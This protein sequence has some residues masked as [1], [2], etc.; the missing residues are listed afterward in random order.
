MSLAIA[1]VL[2]S[3]LAHATWNLLAARGPGDSRAFLL[4]Y[5]LVGAVAVLP[6]AGVSLA[7][8]SDPGAVLRQALVLGVVSGLLHT[9]YAVSLQVSY[10][11]GD[12]GIVYPV[13]RG[14]GPLLAVLAGAWVASEAPSPLGWA[15]IACVL[16]GVLLA[17]SDQPG[18][19]GSRRRGVRAG[20]VG[21]LVVG[22]TIGAYTVWDDHA[23]D[24]RGADPLAYYA[25][26]GLVQLLVVLAVAGRGRVSRA[27]D[28]ARTAPLTVLGVG[29]LVPLSYLLMLFA[30]TLAPLAVIAP[31]RASSVVMG[32]LGA[33]VLM[34]EGSP[35]RRLAA[36]AVVTAGIA[37]IGWGA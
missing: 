17:A 1:L 25:V 3:A 22:L 2:L 5:S 16:A 21:G 36:A 15:G 11:H 30:M 6:V 19:A 18:D 34:H 8:A 26:T 9:A 12:V 24:A 32:A 23:V 14:T 4:A 33:A 35:A 7:S 13:S 27:R 28:A 37:L 31:L 10:R 29:V 20:V